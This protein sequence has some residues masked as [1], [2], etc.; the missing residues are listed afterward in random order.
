MIRGR[1]RAVIYLQVKEKG[2][3]GNQTITLVQDNLTLTLILILDF[4]SPD[5]E[6]ETSTI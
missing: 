5:Y 3:R 1:E 2:L 6:K 4:Q